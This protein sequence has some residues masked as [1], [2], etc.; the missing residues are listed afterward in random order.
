MA[1]PNKNSVNVTQV[2]LTYTALVGDVAKTAAALDLDPDFVRKLAHEE[3]WQSKLE[4][5]CLIGKGG[6]PGDW[7]RA[8]NR[9]LC[10]VQAHQT[11]EVIGRVISRFQDMT[12]EEIIEAIASVAKD[13]TRHVSGRFFAD[14]TAAMEK[15]HS[16]AYCALGDTAGERKENASDDAD[17][18]N[19][20]ALHAAVLQ[21]LNN[22]KINA[23][24]VVSEVAKATE[25]QVKQLTAPSADSMPTEPASSVPI[26]PP[27]SSVT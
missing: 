16:M 1:K 20:T 9:A 23:I 17:V 13:G 21:A 18:V 27:E 24:D 15:C 8:A 5:I 25:I 6:K 14:L 2:F 4:R 7:E 12:D 19:A 26:I 11:R 10:Y 22:P 3:G